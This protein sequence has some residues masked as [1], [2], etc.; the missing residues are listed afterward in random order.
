MRSVRIEAAD[1]AGRERL[2]RYCARPPFALERLRELDGRA[3]ALRERQ[4][5]SGR[6]RPAAADAAG[7][8]R[9]AGGAGAAAADPPSSLL[10]RAGAE[11][12]SALGGHRPR[13]HRDDLAARTQATTR[14]QPAYRRAARYAWA[15]L[16]ARIYEVF[17]LV[18]PHCG[19]AMRVIAVITD[20]T[21]IHGILVELGEP[22]AR[23][24]IAPARGPP[25]CEPAGAED[26]PSPDMA[27]PPTPACEFDQRIAW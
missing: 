17:P 24:R 9:P 3:P 16:L 1:R 11:L 4:T 15:A 25:L 27:F 14:R 5:R 13:V 20:P 8:A 18:C 2:L 22:I 12:T 19:G 23:P 7:A 6:E 21:T 10:R 26:D